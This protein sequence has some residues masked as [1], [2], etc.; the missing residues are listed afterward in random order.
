MAYSLE[1]IAHLDHTREFE[2]LNQKFK[3]FNPF[4]VLKVER[5]EIR[6]SNFLGWLLDPNENH[7]LG[8][9]FVKKILSR[10][11]TKPENDEKIANA[12][13]LLHMY[14]SFWDT[15]VMREVKTSM[16][17]SI[18][19][20]LKIPS[21][22]LI[23]IIENKFYSGESKGQLEDYLAYA[24]EEYS[25]YEIIPIFLTLSTDEPS[26]EDYFVL[27]YKDILEI[28]TQYIE[29]HKDAI[30][31]NVYH[32]L[33]YYTAILQ[34]ELV[35]DEEAI[36][37]ALDVYQMNRYAID[38]L[39]VSQHLEYHTKPR[40]MELSKQ[41]ESFQKTE[42]DLLNQLYEKN[43]ETID[44]VFKIGSN[45]IREAF[46]DFVKNEEMPE[47]VYKAHVS[48][49]NFILPDWSDFEEVIGKPEEDYWLGQG[50][51]IWFKRTWDERLK[52]NVEVGPI[53]YES[54]YRLLTEL[55]KQGVSFQSSGKLE[56]KKYTKVYTNTINIVDWANKQEIVNGMESLYHDP[57]INNVF[58]QIAVAIEKMEESEEIHI[59][60]TRTHIQ[61]R[62]G[63]FPKAP[64]KKFSKAYNIHD[65]D[66][67]FK[68]YNV[69]FLVAAFR[70]LEE[71]Y[72]KTREKWWWHDS[73]FTYWFERL[74]DDRLK[75]TLELGPLQP[76]Q[77]QKIIEM[78]EEHHNAFQ[79]RAKLPTA[80]YTRLFS[81]SKVITNWED[82][83][84]VFQAMKTLYE[85]SIN[86]KLL[87]DIS[88]LK[89]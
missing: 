80:K 33:R 76:E 81:D 30:S 67:R 75:L 19:L 9:F 42:K 72:G 20:L 36:E 27:D 71:I 44:Y 53:P 89:D 14:R 54:R 87:A 49:P 73:T 1:S 69:S 43:K 3:R 7:Q 78:L 29:L 25:G 45:V 6:H 62:E 46:L 84:E 68:K 2:Q 41:L 55:E 85:D 24:R 65:D 32:F 31:H 12:D 35:D 37:L 52:I 13:V 39:Y 79:S 23:V 83:E 70:E 40:Y 8:D 66:Y 57:D 88:S 59:S 5:F 16:N 34:E 21:Q 74:K 17:R 86:R 4:K 38:L 10:L 63:E 50:L 26:Y 22:N 82:S 61:Q 11:V 60:Q 51:I 47:E 77:R 56:G 58:K 48:T 28:I 15:Q 64:F 18:D